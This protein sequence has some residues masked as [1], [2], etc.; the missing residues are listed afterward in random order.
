MNMIKSIDPWSPLIFK[1]KFESDL[2]NIKKK[3]DTV[4]L[5]KS[6]NHKNT[7]SSYTYG[8]NPLLW[9]EFKSFAPF[10]SDTINYCA[11]KWKYSYKEYII[12]NS[13]FV[14]IHKDGYVNPHI[15]RG[16]QMT[17][18]FCIENI[19]SKI[20]VKNP[21]Q[22]HWSSVHS[23]ETETMELENKDYEI[24]VEAGDLLVMPPWIYHAASINNC[25]I[26]SC[27]MALN[28]GGLD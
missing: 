20:T 16:A 11:S 7:V 3:V 23:I 12:Q 10:L 24:D 14:N 4:F 22:Y 19:G 9:P 2:T 26:P 6:L 15:H 13:W 27:F 18:I 8:I 1:G 17:G 21:L 5:N 25:N 28:I